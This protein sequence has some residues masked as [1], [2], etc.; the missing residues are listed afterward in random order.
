MQVLRRGGLRGD[1]KV[2]PKE[3]DGR[4]AQLRAQ[5]KDDQASKLSDGKADKP[6]KPKGKA[7]AS[8]KAKA[9]WKLPDD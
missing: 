9:G 6:G 3:V 1:K 5:I 8:G 4:V 7:K 2:D